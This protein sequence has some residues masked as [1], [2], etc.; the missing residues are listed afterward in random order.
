MD[1]LIDMAR[2][3][4]QLHVAARRWLLALLALA[5]GASPLAALGQVG[6]LADLNHRSEAYASG[7]L[8]RRGYVM[9]HR[10]T[11][12]GSSYWEFWWT[13]ARSQCVRLAI[14]GGQ[15][16]QLIDTDAGSC[17]TRPSGGNPASGHA[18]DD[19]EYQRADHAS[20]EMTRRGYVMIDQVA[21]EGTSHWQY[22]WNAAIS[23]CVSM[24]VDGDQVTQVITA[25]S[26]LCRK[27]AGGSPGGGYATDDLVNRGVDQAGREMM[28]RGYVMSHQVAA[29]GSS[30]WQFWWNAASGQCMRM[31]V[32]GGRVTQVIAADAGSCRRQPGTGGS[33]GAGYGTD[34]LMNL[35]VDQANRE[36]LR[37]GDALTHTESSKGGSYW[38][39]W[40]DSRRARC[41]RL[42]INGGKVTQITPT[43]ARSCR[44]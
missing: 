3:G 29:K 20:R 19:L 12:K 9:S 40:W 41:T 23:R 4:E 43:D 36:L 6:N 34:D 22:W 11:A 39:Y 1:L 14:N 13:A 8:S 37:R 33:P 42:A 24:A 5:I 10:E 44:R 31:A 21:A 7:E 28:R 17:K 38:Q 32:N 30:Y 2:R 27:P 18:T 35:R 26:R 16:T 25:D 15:V